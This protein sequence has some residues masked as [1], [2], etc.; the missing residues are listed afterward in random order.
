MSSRGADSGGSRLLLMIGSA[1]ASFG[2]QPLSIFT[3]MMAV[4]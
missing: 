2:G 1:I 3:L 4:D